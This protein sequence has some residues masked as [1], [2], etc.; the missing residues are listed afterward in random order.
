MDNIEACLYHCNKLMGLLEEEQYLISDVFHEE[1]VASYRLAI[2]KE[3]NELANTMQKLRNL[4]L[5]K[6]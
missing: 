1:M 5:M 2:E 6:E 4:L 3:K